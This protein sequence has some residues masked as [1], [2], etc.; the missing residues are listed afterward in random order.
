MAQRSTRGPATSSTT[1]LVALALASGGAPRAAVASEGFPRVEGEIRIEVQSDL[2]YRASNREEESNDL[3]T[4][5]EPK[6]RFGLTPRIS[7]SANLVVEP[8]READ[9]GRDRYFGDHGAF[10]EELFLGYETPRWGLRA[11]KINPHFG[12]AWDRAPGIYGRVFREDYELRDHRATRRGR[13]PS[14]RQRPHRQPCARDGP[15]L[16]RHGLSQQLRSR[17]A[18]AHACP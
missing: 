18:A 14:R 15:A 3:F 9:P 6:L 7:L 11:G 1:F 5:I 17:A 8:V 13:L 4:K 10:V 2:G 12:F 16:R